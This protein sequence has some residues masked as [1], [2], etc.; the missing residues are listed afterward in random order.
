MHCAQG[1]LL[2][3]ALTGSSAARSSHWVIAGIRQQHCQR[4]QLHH[5]PTGHQADNL[6]SVPVWHWPQLWARCICNFSWAAA[7]RSFWQELLA[8]VRWYVVGALVGVQGA[9]GSLLSALCSCTTGAACCCLSCLASSVLTCAARSWYC[10]CMAASSA[11]V[12]HSCCFRAVKSLPS[13]L[14]L[15]SSSAGVDS[16]LPTATKAVMAWSST[17]QNMTAVTSSTYT[18]STTA[19]TTVAQDIMATLKLLFRGLLRTRT[20]IGQLWRSTQQNNCIERN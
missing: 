2:R 11:W 16:H 8:V 20:Y 15:L 19:R 3:A 14:W 10:C 13:L 1:H 12:L 5:A 18:T 7:G 9:S 6:Y 17:I 4:T